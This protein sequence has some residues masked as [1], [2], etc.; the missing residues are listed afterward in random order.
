MARL[1]SKEKR[2]VKRMAPRNSV[3]GSTALDQTGGRISRKSRSKK[4][5]GFKAVARKISR[6]QHLPMEQA[7]AELAAATRRHL[8]G[9]LMDKLPQESGI[10]NGRERKR[11]A[12]VTDPQDLKMDPRLRNAVAMTQANSP[13]DPENSES[14]S[15]LTTH[16]HKLL[17]NIGGLRKPR[18]LSSSKKGGYIFTTLRN[19][20]VE[21]KGNE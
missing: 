6:R 15:N 19:V 9:G 3:S 10:T 12:E 14:L 18:S 11:K 8:G 7:D 4:H 2:V 20:T 17:K 1:S 5:P 13:L 21:P 16:H